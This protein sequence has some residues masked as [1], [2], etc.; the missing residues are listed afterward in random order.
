MLESIVAFILGLFSVFAPNTG[1]LGDPFLSLQV[2]STPTSGYVLKTDGTDSLWVATSTLGITA[3]PGG[4]NT[5]VQY[6]NSGTLAG[7]ST[8]T[9]DGSALTMAATSTFATSTFDILSVATTTT[10][11]G[12]LNIDGDLAITPTESTY[13]FTSC[14]G[15]DNCIAIQNQEPGQQGIL[16]IMAAD[17]DG[18]DSVHL[19]IFGVGTPADISNREKLIQG[20][21]VANSQYEIYTEAQG[22]GTLRPLSIYTEGNAAQLQL[23]TNGNVGVGDATPASLFTVGSSD[24]FQINSAG[25][26]ASGTWNGAI[27]AH[28]YG[29][30]ELNISSV[31]VGD[32]IAGASAGTLEIV[33]GGAAS[34]GDVLTIQADGTA[35]FEAVPASSFDSTAVDN[36]TWSDGTNASNIWTFDVSGTDHTMTFGSGLVTF[37][38]AVTVTGAL[39]GTLTGNADTA[40]ALAANGSNCSAGSAPLGVDASGAVESCTDYEEDLSNEAGLYAALSDVSLFLEDLID[41]T[42]PQLG[43][44][45]DA[46]GNNFAD[47]GVL[48]L[49][50]QADADADVAGQGQFWVNTATPNEAYFTDDAGND[51][52]LVY[53]GGAFHD[54]FSDF[55]ANEHIDWTGA[56]AGTIHATNYVDNELTEEEVEDFVGGM[57]G[58]TETGISVTY[59]DGTNDIDFVVDLGTAIDTSEIT[60]GTIIEPDLNVDDSPSDGDVLTYDTTGTN[61]VWET[62][63]DLVNT[64]TGAVD[65][66]GITSFEIPNGASPTVNATGEIA[67]DTSS[68]NGQLQIDMG[69][70]TVAFVPDFDKSWSVASSSPDGSSNTFDTAT[71]T[72]EVWHPSRPVT[73]NSI[74]CETDVGTLY[75]RVGDGTNWTEGVACSAT[76]TA[77]ESLNNNTFTAREDVIIEIGT[78][79]TSPDWVT[80][81]LN[82]N[83]TTQ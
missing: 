64:I 56:S 1:A 74:Y 71:T 29:G 43:G 80:V 6:N 18:T 45:L 16:R 82:F 77:D 66:G 23:A 53:S 36:T 3:S 48:F 25:T 2:G 62:I 8:L 30:L 13:L 28:E 37:S 69:T 5:Q 39:T 41:D 50:E 35:N 22:T 20:W 40:T 24:A 32:I 42:T 46:E 68:P 59:Q 73:L 12:V 83:Y 15:A 78:S 81:D 4:A 38:N 27:I 75:A 57:L 7:L 72:W 52:E 11:P 63:L 17:G 55:V 34:D 10:G 70:S 49:R 31:G 21:S 54:G 19:D 58:G 33:D 47:G 9:T 76:P 67:V 60:D 61:F 44:D 51:R 79:A 14:T 65:W 26:V